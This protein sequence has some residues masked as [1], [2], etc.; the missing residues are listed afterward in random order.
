MGQRTPELHPR[1]AGA[2]EGRQPDE[3]LARDLIEGHR[4]R[5][6]QLPACL[7]EA[8]QLPDHPLHAARAL[9][10][11]LQQALG[12]AEVGLAAGH[13]HAQAHR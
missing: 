2:R 13:L 4:L 12:F 10:G 9:E 5:V 11:V 7:R 3:G 1:A 8:E 6:D